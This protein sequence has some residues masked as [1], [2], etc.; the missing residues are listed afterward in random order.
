MDIKL[1]S[2]NGSHRSRLR[3]R[4]EKSGFESFADH[5]VVELLL[6]LAVPRSDVSSTAKALIARFGNLRGILDASPEELRAVPGI[7]T[8]TPMMLKLIR[9]TADLYLQQCAETTDTSSDW[10]LISPDEWFPLQV[11]F[12]SVEEGQMMPPP[13]IDDAER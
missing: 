1:R 3:D 7:G 13:P 2:Q 9:A 6:T 11:R 10:P 5:E 8:I 12:T 4:F